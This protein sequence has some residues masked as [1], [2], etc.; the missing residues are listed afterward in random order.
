MCL[1]VL[2]FQKCLAKNIILLNFAYIFIKFLIFKLLSV[3]IFYG[4]L[5]TTY[6]ESET[7]KNMKKIIKSKKIFIFYLSYNCGT[8]GATS[9]KVFH[10]ILINMERNWIQSAKHQEI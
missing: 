3:T 9:K 10:S 4:G 1:D 2:L 6:K 5:R 7:W 8:V